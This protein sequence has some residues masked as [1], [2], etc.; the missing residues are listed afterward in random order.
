M[1]IRNKI[2]FYWKYTVNIS[3]LSFSISALKILELHSFLAAKNI[4]EILLCSRDI[5]IISNTLWF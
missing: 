1:S 5:R 4:F 2:L 3:G